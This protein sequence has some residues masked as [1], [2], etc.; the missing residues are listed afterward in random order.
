MPRVLDSSKTAAARGAGTN[1]DYS[2]LKNLLN[3][4]DVSLADVAQG[5]GNAFM[6]AIQDSV[7][8]VFGVIQA[9]T[10]IDFSPLADLFTGVLGAT[11]TDPFTGETSTG[12]DFSSY[13]QQFSAQ[14]AAWQAALANDISAGEAFA[15]SVESAVDS[16]FAT[17]VGLLGGTPADGFSAQQLGAILVALQSMTGQISAAWS[18]LLQAFDPSLDLSDPLGIESFFAEFTS[19]NSQLG[20]EM[21]Q[22]GQIFDQQVV[23]PISEAVSQAQTGFNNLVTK[24][25]LMFRTPNMVLDPDF[26]V[27]AMWSNAAGTQ[28]TNESHSGIYSW[29]LV[30][31]G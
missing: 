31:Q 1:S 20:T 6:V 8:Q 5:T 15:G 12:I 13:I 2:P 29:Q 7:G 21:T 27:A 24:L 3:Y 28:T 4:Q 18:A 22:L 9:V 10:G 16:A 19:A 17:V 23:T 26:E 25:T 11:T 14:A 30:G